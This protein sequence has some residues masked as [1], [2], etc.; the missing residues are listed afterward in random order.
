MHYRENNYLVDIVIVNWNSGI[1]LAKCLQ[2]LYR[3]GHQTISSITVVDN[4]STDGSEKQEILGLPINLLQTNANLGFGRACNIGVHGGQAPYILFLNPDAALFEGTLQTA[5]AF[6]E[7]SNN[8]SI[9]VCGVRL[10]E[11]NGNTQRHSARFPTFSRMIADCFGISH[12]F[13]GGALHNTEFDHLT[14][15]DVDHVI[16]A[17]YL[18]RRPL[19]EQLGGFDSRFFVYLEDLDLSLRVHQ[20]GYRVHYFADA[21]GFHKGGGTSDQVKAQRLYYSMDS[22]L[23]Y[24]F[25][26]FSLPAAVGITLAT[27]IIEPLPRIARALIRFSGIEVNNTLRA[28]AW[29]WK[30][31]LEDPKRY[32]IAPEVHSTN[33]TEI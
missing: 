4:G 32:Y 10:T 18:I 17:F 20:A 19:F 9:G 28:F 12:I 27:L 7:D 1:W 14:S 16:G 22:R 29:L 23:F 13:S 25:K 26:H 33:A 11:E 21:V 24:A 31:L 30:G 15:R 3:F 2:S 6:M 5:V 8:A